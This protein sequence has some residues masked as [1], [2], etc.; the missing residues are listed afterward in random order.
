MKKK[1]LT[2]I[3]ALPILMLVAC[4]NQTGVGSS[5]SSS[6]NSVSSQTP[7]TSSSTNKELPSLQQVMRNIAELKNYTYTMNDEIFDMTTNIYYTEKAYYVDYI[8]PSTDSAVPFG[9]AE[10]NSNQVFEFIIED[11]QV[12]PGDFYRNQQGSVI[13]GLWDNAIIS[14]ADFNIDAFSNQVSEDN[15]YKITDDANKLLFAVLAGYG[16]V[17][18]LPYIEVSVEVTSETSFISTVTFT[19]DNPNYTGSCVGKLHS[20]GETEIPYIDEYIEN[21]GSAKVDLSENLISVLQTL[22]NDNNYTLEVTNSSNSNHYIDTVTSDYYYSDNKLTPSLSKG[23][24]NLANSA[25]NFT[26]EGN[27][28][29]IG[30][31]ITYSS[32]TSHS[33]WDNVSSIHNFKNINLSNLSLEEVE[34]GLKLSNNVSVLTSLY[35]LVH[36]VNYFPV[37]NA[38]TDYALFTSI[39]DTKLE[40]DLH[41]ES[42]ATFH[43]V[44]T[45]INTTK[46]DVIE[47]YIEENKDFDS[48]DIAKLIETFTSIKDSKNYK[49]VLE[50]KFSTF[51][52]NL[53]EIGNI[54]INVSETNYLVKNLSD[55]TKSY[56]YKMNEGKLTR[57]TLV[58]GEEVLGDT[59]DGDM[60][61]NDVFTSLNNLDTSSFK[62]DATLQDEYI[63]TDS[64]T[65][66]FI[67]NLLTF[68]SSD[69][70]TYISKLTL[71]VVSESSISI[72]G[73][74]SF[75]G[76]FSAVISAAE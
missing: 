41:I 22:K 50:N 3:L 51:V 67:A 56:G 28:V 38:E 18:V 37:V 68:P 24:L 9:Y 15:T 59:Y 34:G 63:V 33:F 55:E 1:F 14:F 40:F 69:F 35:D 65:I 62:A 74:A 53:N 36:T 71:E 43:V 16:D 61:E 10:D 2:V 72:I 42:E 20:I 6:E 45:N 57:Y 19:P 30:S 66:E 5:S 32:S 73:T 12:V 29:V 27:Q 75:Y 49:I 44:I 21:G 52:P 17:Y 70:M 64:A 48:S 7:I 76:S 8:N 58:E 46:N 13:S 25:Y 31:E 47:S 26:L 60:L 39:S 11:N 23:Y 4:N 54:E